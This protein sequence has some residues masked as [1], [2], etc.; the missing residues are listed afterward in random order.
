MQDG[1]HYCLIVRAANGVQASITF[2][3]SGTFYW[4]GSTAPTFP[5]TVG[6]R[7]VITFIKTEGITLG[8]YADATA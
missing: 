5:L 2:S 6:N 4:Q 1:G 7:T 8:Y 3:A